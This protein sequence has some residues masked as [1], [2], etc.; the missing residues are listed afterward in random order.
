M[1][2]NSMEYVLLLT[3][4]VVAYYLTPNVRMRQVILLLGSV[5]F[6]ASWIPIYLLLLLFVLGANFIVAA[7]GARGR[8]VLAATVA[9]NL[10]VLAYFK[11]AQFT[12]DNIFGLFNVFGASAEA[13]QFSIILPLGIS[14]Y[15]F[16]AMGYVIDVRRGELEPERD[17]LRFFLF[18]MFFP[19]LIAGPICRGAQLLPQLKI[20][21][22]FN[23]ST[24]IFG[25]LMFSVGLTLKVVFAD[26][27][28]P[29]VDGVYADPT[30]AAPADALTAAIAFGIVILGDFWG[31]STMAIG[32]AMMFGIAMP[33]NFN[34]PYIAT[35][36]QSFWRRWHITLSFWLRDYL[37]KPLGGSRVGTVT[38]ARNLMIVMLL[39]G[40]WHGAAWTFVIWGG[41]HG[42]W[43]IVERIYRAS[44]SPW[45]SNAP[46]VLMAGLGWCV[47][48][49][50]VFVGWV[51]FR[52]ETTS[53]ALAILSL[54]AQAPSAPFSD[55][56]QKTL[57][58]CAVFAVAM[59]PLHRLTHR[60]TAVRIG[61]VGQVVVAFWLF[62][63]SIVLSAEDVQEFIYFQF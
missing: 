2:F 40:L 63:I 35:S 42:A 9:F 41:I 13:P 17:P 3:A 46:K 15:I 38:V 56:A 12:A 36:L 10:A 24:V 22:P 39:G 28:S 37:F 21:A 45:F 8:Y 59:T 58:I 60:E 53:D 34:L 27:L 55:A 19:Q 62:V 6:Y 47:T 50:V 30:A 33:Y 32:S 14:F 51:F 43:Q 16:Q 49:F 44:I 26:N 29:F 11:Y 23:L 54:A 52:A 20:K 18:V 25:V 31:Y 1:L 5:V 48:M 7:G 57:I 4:C 61:T